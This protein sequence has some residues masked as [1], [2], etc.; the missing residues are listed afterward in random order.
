MRFRAVFAMSQASAAAAAEFG[1]FAAELK[2][3]S[4]SSSS[5]DGNISGV[6]NGKLGRKGDVLERFAIGVWCTGSSSSSS[7]QQQKRCCI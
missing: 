7:V 1:G 6:R 4:S 2:K 3:K 5:S